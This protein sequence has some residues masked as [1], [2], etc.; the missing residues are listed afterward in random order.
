MGDD[1][2]RPHRSLAASEMPAPYFTEVGPNL[3]PMRRLSAGGS[4]DRP[5]SEEAALLPSC[6][7]RGSWMLRRRRRD[8]AVT[9]TQ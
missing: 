9:P 4:D 2:Y 6:H 3:F 8:A 1:R 5:E 7:V